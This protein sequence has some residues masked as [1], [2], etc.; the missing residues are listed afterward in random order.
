[1]VIVPAAVLLIGL[2]QAALAVPPGNELTTTKEEK[3]LGAWRGQTGCAGNLVF[4]ADG[5]YEWKQRGPGGDDSAGTWKVRGDGLP[6]TLVLTCKK[7]EF[8]EEVGKTIEVTL[9]RLDDESLAVKYASQ[10]V[11][12]YARVKK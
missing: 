6:A 8:L 9:I 3:I 1:M 12:R 2:A 10:T 4:R 11:D 5:T 7:S